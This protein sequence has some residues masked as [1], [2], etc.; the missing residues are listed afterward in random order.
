M[1][2]LVLTIAF[3]ITGV[4]G[5]AQ[6]VEFNYDYTRMTIHHGLGS[7][8]MPLHGDVYI[9][10]GTKEIPDIYV[11]I[12][13]PG[14]IHRLDITVV[15][16]PRTSEGQWRFVN[17]VEKADFKVEFVKYSYDFDFSIMFTNPDKARQFIDPKLFNVVKTEIIDHGKWEYPKHPWD[18]E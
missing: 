12:V 18:K 1:K 2:K 17:N 4:F 10:N 6:K 8:T 11:A 7:T 9:T 5:F 13:Q 14:C 16:T 3:F 15:D